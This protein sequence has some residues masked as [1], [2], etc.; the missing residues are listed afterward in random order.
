MTVLAPMPAFPPAKPKPHKHFLGIGAGQQWD[1]PVQD[2]RRWGRMHEDDS[3]GRQ[4]GQSEIPDAAVVVVV[5]MMMCVT[6]GVE[7]W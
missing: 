4:R 7:G 2:R 5:V 1:T 6:T 3:N